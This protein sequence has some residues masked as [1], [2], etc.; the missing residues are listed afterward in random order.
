MKD[1]LNVIAVAILLIPCIVIF[2]EG[3]SLLCNMVGIAYLLALVGLSRTKV[4][5]RF[6]RNVY[7]SNLRLHRNFFNV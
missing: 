4:G 2:S 1:L 7:R 6:T 3:G 5:K